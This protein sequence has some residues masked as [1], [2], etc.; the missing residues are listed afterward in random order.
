MLITLAALP[1]ALAWMLGTAVP[2]ALD[3]YEVHAAPIAG[4]ALLGLALT[5]PA[6]LIW[7]LRGALIAWTA[8]HVLTAVASRLNSGRSCRPGRRSRTTRCARRCTSA[9]RRT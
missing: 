4:Q 5:I 3:R 9:R 1:F 8:S 2:L 7:D 6:A